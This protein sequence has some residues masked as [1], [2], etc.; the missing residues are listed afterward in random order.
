MASGKSNNHLVTKHVGYL[1]D[2]IAN[3]Y[4]GTE[5]DINPSNLFLPISS[6]LNVGLEIYL[7]VRSKKY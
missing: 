6:D 2:N 1:P 5:L 3:K 4:A 7:L